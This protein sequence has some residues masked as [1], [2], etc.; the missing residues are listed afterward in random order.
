MGR[1]WEDRQGESE[2]KTVISLASVLACAFAMDA[3]ITATLAD[4]LAAYRKSE[5]GTIRASVRWP[6]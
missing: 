1:S 2:M 4:C 5:F 6:L 3:Q